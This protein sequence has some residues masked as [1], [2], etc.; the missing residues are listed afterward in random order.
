MALS[1]RFSVSRW[2][3][4]IIQILIWQCKMHM[5]TRKLQGLVSCFASYPTI[6]IAREMTAHREL[7]NTNFERVISKLGI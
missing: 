2:M 1:A 7:F 6:E 4:L 5:F 3:T